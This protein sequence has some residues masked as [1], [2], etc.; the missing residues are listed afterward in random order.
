M[1]SA[2]QQ[3]KELLLV[4]VMILGRVHP[5]VALDQLSC[6]RLI[7]DTRSTYHLLCLIDVRMN[8]SELYNDLLYLKRWDWALPRCYGLTDQSMHASDGLEL[9]SV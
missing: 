2:C 8:K 3:M 9:T 5:S 7:L 4:I 1:M 6:C